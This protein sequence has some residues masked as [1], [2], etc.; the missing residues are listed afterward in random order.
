[1]SEAMS[2]PLETEMTVSACLTTFLKNFTSRIVRSVM[3]QR[4]VFWRLKLPLL[5]VLLPAR[6]PLLVE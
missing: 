6:I 5:R 3:G 4:A 1:M 2:G